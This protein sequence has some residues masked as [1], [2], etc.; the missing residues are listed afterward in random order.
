MKVN[1][2]KQTLNPSIHWSMVWDLLSKLQ[3][4]KVGPLVE[5]IYSL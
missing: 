1:T 2:L 5:L 3:K 4:P